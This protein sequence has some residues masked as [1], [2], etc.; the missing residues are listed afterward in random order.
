MKKLGMIGGISWHS[1]AKY[2]KYLNEYANRNISDYT[3]CNCIINSVNFAEIRQHQEANN[4][5][6]IESI[7]SKAAYELLLAGAEKIILCSNTPHKATQWISSLPENTFIHIAEASG[8]I[9]KENGVKKAGFLGTMTSMIEPFITSKISESGNLEI[10]LPEK[11]DM[12]IIN[13]GIFK[14]LVKGKISEQRRLAYLSIIEKM[15]KN[16]AEAI[17][18]GCTEIGILI[19]QSMTQI[20]LYDTLEMHCEIVAKEIFN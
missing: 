10:L 4:W 7:L 13:D 20:P 8:R 11:H 18:M 16:G 14:E 5:T 9:L 1:T 12:K 2:Y 6:K 19:N 15:S 17:I 3:S